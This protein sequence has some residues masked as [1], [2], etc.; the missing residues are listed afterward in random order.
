MKH[1]SSPIVVAFFLVFSCSSAKRDFTG[2]EILINKF[3][4]KITDKTHII[5][6]TKQDVMAKYQTY[7][8]SDNEREDGIAAQWSTNVEKF[9]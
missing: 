9:I 7:P 1:K 5:Y 6:H 3:G 8:W 4:F 2:E